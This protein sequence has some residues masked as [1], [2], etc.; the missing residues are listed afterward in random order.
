MRLRHPFGLSLAI[1]LGTSL[2]GSNLGSNLGGI[3]AADSVRETDTPPRFERDIRPIFRAHCFDCHGAN[4]EKKG[5]LDLRLV[6]FLIRGGETG[7]AIVPGKPEE[8]F[9]LR[10]VR[11]GEMPP[12][13]ARLSAE[14]IDTLERWIADGARTS[15]PEPESIGAGLGLIEEERAFWAFQ[16]IRRSE[17]PT[18]SDDSDD[19]NVRNAIDALLIDAM[20]EDLTLSPDADRVP[21]IRRLALDLTGLPPRPAEVDRFLHDD[22]PLAYEALV[23]RLIASPHFGERWARHW[24]DVAGYA[25]SEGANNAD[26]PRPWAFRYRDRVIRALNDDLPFDRFLTEQL[27]GDHLAGPKQGEW[28]A[29]QIDLLAATGFLRM[30]ADGTG[31]GSDN[32]EARNKVVADTLKIVGSSLLGLSVACAQCHDH[33][34]DPISHRDYYALRAVFEPALDWKRWTRPQDRGVSL[35]TEADRKRS[36]KIEAEASKIVAERNAKQKEYLEAAFAKELEKYEEAL[37]G[38]LRAAWET[39]EKERT[40]EQRE[41][42]VKCP[43]ANVKPGVLYQYNQKAADDLKARDNRI[44]AVRAKKPPKIF[45]RALVEPPGSPAV[46]HR[47]HRGDYRQP[48]EVVEPAVP[49][50][51][52]ALGADPKIR[53][54]AMPDGT[55]GRRLAFATWLTSRENPLTSRVLVNRVWR[56]LLGRGIVETPSDF[57]KLGVRPSHPALLDWLAD[58]FQRDGWSVKRLIRRIVTSAAY[59]QTTRREPASASVDPDNRYFSRQAVR[60]LEA[61]T[62]RDRMLAVSGHLDRMMYGTPVAVK[63]DDAGQVIVDGDSGRRSV[64]VRVT[65]SQPVGLLQAFDAPVMETNCESRTSSTVATQS[66]MLLNGEFV[67]GEARRLVA[68]A[69]RE[70]QELVDAELVRDVRVDDT[71]TAGAWSYGWGALDDTTGRV[72]SFRVLGHW[73]G[74]RYQGGPKLPDPDPV[75]SWALLTADGGHPGANPGGCAIRRWIA[76]RA[77]KISITGKLHHPSENG[78]GVRGRIVS[79]DAGIAG[80]WTA[81]KAEVETAVTELEVRAGATVDFVVDSRGAHTSDSFNWTVTVKYLGGAREVWRSKDDFA[82]PRSVTSPARTVAAAWKLAYGRTIERDELDAAVEF[83]RGQLQTIRE[84]TALKL[85]DGRSAVDQALINLCQMLLISNEFLYVD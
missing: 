22:D 71:S 64:Y 28:T 67:L 61:E 54:D 57:G 50:V 34:Y 52:V 51:L 12:G 75:L 29:E 46:T 23:D 73:N 40:T 39:P 42:F 37:R 44:A 84:D 30:A 27:A 36:S 13:D 66:L 68:R 11:A 82:G 43:A 59:R 32:D 58:E 7:P 60:R 8:S 14:E 1:V 72:S 76:Q 5:K 24:L 49:E 21:L 35:F 55:T 38:P 16:P 70:A 81:H 63:S 47:F 26:N 65:R 56:Q 78:D 15:K 74:S 77:G 85:P 45:V 17:V 6:R 18:V 20:P 62:I 83:L 9:L 48:K 2:L 53:P 25:D 19:P 4:D 41:L 79:S 31:S 80:E 69:G 3:V 33:R 10:R